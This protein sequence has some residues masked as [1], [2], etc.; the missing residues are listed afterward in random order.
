MNRDSR[1]PW[2]ETT[3]DE[4]NWRWLSATMHEQPLGVATRLLQTVRTV[5]KQSDTK[6]VLRY[7]TGDPAS[8]TIEFLLIARRTGEL[9]QVLIGGAVSDDGTNPPKS[10]RGGVDGPNLD[11]PSDTP[12]DP[13][14]A[15]TKTLKRTQWNVG[16]DDP[17]SEQWAKRF[18]FR[19]LAVLDVLVWEC[20][21]D[22]PSEPEEVQK[23]AS[24]RLTP[25]REPEGLRTLVESYEDT[26]DCPAWDAIREPK[27]V[28][29]GYRAASTYWP[30]G[31]YLI[32]IEE[33]P[34]VGVVI[35]GRDGS[36]DAS[37]TP[38]FELTYI[39]LVRSQRGR[40]LGDATLRLVRKRLAFEARQNVASS[41][42]LISTA[43]DR[44]NRPANRL[45]RRLGFERIFGERVWVAE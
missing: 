4:C 36:R 25:W 37:A 15:Q 31:W 18:G 17:W 28:L 38:W 44:A 14:A 12:S 42:F 3:P 45:Y 11:S 23:D 16:E 5:A 27:D 24:I 39:G 33:G 35:I 29:A 19:P 21:G 43:V 26:E 22:I 40:G 34:P 8:G 10:L 2:I 9:D 1:L 32:E 30:A 7:R 41:S 20:G 6:L 13:S